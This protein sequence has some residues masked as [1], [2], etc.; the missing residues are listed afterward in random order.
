ME[1]VA[2]NATMEGTGYL[3]RC[4]YLLHDRDTK[5]WREFR[6]TLAVGGV[7]CLALPTRSPNLNSYA[8][9]WVCSVKEECLSRL[10]LFREH[11]LR[12]AVSNFLEHFH[13]ERNHQGRGNL[14]LFPTG[15]TASATQATA[16]RCH[17]RLGGLLKYSRAA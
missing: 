11:S 5:F 16:V 9:R 4:R 12:R 6:E 2:R 7:K 15:T 1:Q 3:N 10:I 14:L 17:E 8:E 13:H